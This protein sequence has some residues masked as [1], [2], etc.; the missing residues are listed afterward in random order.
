MAAKCASTIDFDSCA[1]CIGMDWWW[2][3]HTNALANQNSQEATKLYGKCQKWTSTFLEPHNNRN[4]NNI[5][6]TSTPFMVNRTYVAT[7]TVAERVI[8]VLTSPIQPIWNRNRNEQLI[9]FTNWFFFFCFIVFQAAVVQVEL[10]R[11][12]CFL[13][14]YNPFRLRFTRYLYLRDLFILSHCLPNDE[15]SN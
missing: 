10:D 13:M 4:Y 6:N 1:V 3:Q 15:S 2:F 7:R 5:T 11:D 9:H 14:S 8:D 12:I